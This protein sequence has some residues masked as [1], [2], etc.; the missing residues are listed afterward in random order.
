MQAILPI[1]ASLALGVLTVAC[2]N[3]N[4]RE[5][6]LSG[7]A[8]LSTFP[9]APSSVTARDETGRMTHAAV[10]A[11]GLFALPLVKGHTYR[12][13]FDSS[14]AG[15]PVVFPRT[16]GRLDATFVL[17]TGGAALRLGQV[18]HFPGAPAGG[19]HVLVVQIPTSTP[20]PGT[21]TTGDCS[22]CVNDDQNVTCAGSGSGSDT[23]AA[24]SP[25]AN[26]TAEQADGTGELAV[27]DQNVPEEVDGCDNSDDNVEQEG[28]H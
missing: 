9:S 22:D 11:Q 5:S 20:P 13:S 4:A 3:P 19:F 25:A 16:S 7:T 8:A 26:D 21:A 24:A 27:G 2:T 18:R 12:V 17:K 10:N 1:S 23:Q 6:T 15:V 28:E 14:G